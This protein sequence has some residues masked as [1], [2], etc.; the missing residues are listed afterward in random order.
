MMVSVGVAVTR[1]LLV[2]SMSAFLSL[3][4]TDT[5]QLCRSLQPSGSEIKR[6]PPRSYSVKEGVNVPVS[7]IDLYVFL[8][9]QKSVK[10]MFSNENLKK[11]GKTISKFFIFNTIPFNAADC[12]PYYQSMMETIAD[13]SPGIKGPIG[14]QI[15]G[16]YLE[17]EIQELDAYISS[18]KVKWPQ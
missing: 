4:M 6:G 17:E 15:G 10:D 14:Y 2:L 1:S 5:D 11:M 18:M 12:G 9:K 3:V 13:A 7:G 8:S 16:S